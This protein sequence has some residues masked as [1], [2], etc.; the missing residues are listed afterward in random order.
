MLLHRF[1]NFP[2]S[3]SHCRHWRVQKGLIR[4]QSLSLSL[5]LS[6]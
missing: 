3:S 5:S 6:G 4:Q 2:L 1:Y